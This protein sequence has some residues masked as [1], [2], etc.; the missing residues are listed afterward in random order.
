MAAQRTSLAMEADTVFENLILAILA[1]LGFAPATSQPAR[2]GPGPTGRRHA[3]HPAPAVASAPSTGPGP[4]GRRHAIHRV[5]Q[6]VVHAVAQPKPAAALRNKLSLREAQERAYALGLRTTETVRMIPAGLAVRHFQAQAGC[7]PSQDGLGRVT[8]REAEMS[9]GRDL[10]AYVD[11]CLSAG[12]T[13]LS[14]SP[15]TEKEGDALYRLHLKRSME[16]DVELWEAAARARDRQRADAQAAGL[17]QPEAFR[18][19][20][21][22]EVIIAQ[23]AAAAAAALKRR[24]ESAGGSTGKGGAAV[25]RL[26]TAEAPNTDV[27]TVPA[28]PK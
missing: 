22:V 1:F 11:L 13:L 19:P 9:L 26:P 10:V 14:I 23:R 28:G 15:D 25:V 7:A 8:R 5:A 24:A 12:Q 27:P 20:D 16:D 2:V 21:A 6:P 18:I 17:P 3:I 4:G